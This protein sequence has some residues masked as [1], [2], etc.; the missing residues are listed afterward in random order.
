MSGS[1]SSYGGN[2]LGAVLRWTDINNFYKAYITGTN[3]VIQKK[4]TGKTTNLKSTS[5]PAKPGTSYTVLFSIVGT[6]L[7]AKVWPTG[8]TPPGSWMLSTTDSSLSS[9]SCG[10]LMYLTSGIIADVSS[11]QAVQP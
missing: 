2:T 3:L 4:V 7:S 9:G 1:L 11:F 6:T 5:F 10:L 8:S